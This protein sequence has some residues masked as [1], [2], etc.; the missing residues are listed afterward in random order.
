MNEYYLGP[1]I[2]WGERVISERLNGADYTRPYCTVP[3]PPAG[4][5]ST[6]EERRARRDAVAER[7]VDLLNAAERS[8]P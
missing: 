6:I 1:V 3:I 5:S 2:K 4:L 7:I 8:E